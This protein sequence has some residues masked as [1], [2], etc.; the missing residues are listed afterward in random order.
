MTL[1]VFN[2]LGKKITTLVCEQQIPGLHTVFWDGTDNTGAS[3]PSG[4]YLYHLQTPKFSTAKK[5]ILME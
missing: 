2:I 3:L 5:M 4:I 1:S